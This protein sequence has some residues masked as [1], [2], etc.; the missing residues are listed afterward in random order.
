MIQDAGAGAG[1][2]AGADANADV[3]EAGGP[4]ATSNAATRRKQACL[5]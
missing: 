4:I 5:Q 2:G 1:A 3:K